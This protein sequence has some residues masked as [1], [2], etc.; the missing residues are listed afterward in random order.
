MAKPAFNPVDAALAVVGMVLWVAFLHA[1]IWPSGVLIDTSHYF[2]WCL[3][4]W[5]IIAFDRWRTKVREGN[6]QRQEKG[7]KDCNTA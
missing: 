1:I 7:S 4:G 6:A 5:S 2:M 3:I